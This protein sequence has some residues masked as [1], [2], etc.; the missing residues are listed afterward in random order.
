V[1]KNLSNREFSIWERV[2]ET[3]LEFGAGYAGKTKQI[4]WEHSAKTAKHVPKKARCTSN[5]KYVYYKNS[6]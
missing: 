3:R 6:S 2:G 4:L 1:V 5:P